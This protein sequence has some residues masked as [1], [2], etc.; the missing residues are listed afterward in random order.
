[1]LAARLLAG[2]AGLDLALPVVPAWAEPAWHLFVVRH[3]A[4]ERLAGRLAELGI[5]TLV[6]YPVP[7]HRQEAYAATQL[8]K[9][10]L[11]V[12]ERLHREVLSVPLHP[13][14]TDEDADRVIKAFRAALANAEAVASG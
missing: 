3:P 1:V 5:E 7:P 6:H 2:L 10:S 14:M 8:A 4:R 9:L 11:P 13:G 12:S